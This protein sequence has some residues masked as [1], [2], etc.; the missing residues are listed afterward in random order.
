MHL[1]DVSPQR[2]VEQ[3]HLAV[4]GDGGFD[5]TALVALAQAAHPLG[6]STMLL[7]MA[8]PFRR[9]PV[10]ETQCSQPVQNAS[11]Q[12]FALCEY[13]LQVCHAIGQLGIEFFGRKVDVVDLHLEI[14]PRA[15]RI[16]LGGDVVIA[17]KH[18]GCAGSCRCSSF[19]PI[20]GRSW[21]MCDRACP[22][23]Q[24]KISVSDARGVDY[25][26]YFD[27]FIFG[28]VHGNRFRFKV[29]KMLVGCSSVA[30]LYSTKAALR[31]LPKAAIRS[32][33]HA[34]IVEGCAGALQG[35]GP[36]HIIIPTEIL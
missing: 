20:R 3:Q 28:P 23:C 35:D 17:G 36:P 21:A 13:L 19:R 1:D 18:G 7:L 4:D 5:L 10:I 34:D 33:A 11:L 32:K 31:S 15:Q 2:P 9:I 14:L 26:R 12:P 6:V 8:D 25:G 24:G 22:M 27:V 30:R 29:A 16:L